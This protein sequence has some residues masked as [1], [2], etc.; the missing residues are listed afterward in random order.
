MNLWTLRGA[1]AASAPSVT[2]LLVLLAGCGEEARAPDP[3]PES[4]TAWV[5]DLDPGD[6][7]V[8]GGIDFERLVAE[9]EGERHENLLLFRGV[10]PCASCPGIRTLLTLVPENNVYV[11]RQTW[12]EAED[13][14]DR[15]ATTVGRWSE[16]VGLPDNPEALVFRL[17]GEPGEEAVA[18]FAIVTADL[19][20]MLDRE[21]RW[22]DS[23]L[24]YDLHRVN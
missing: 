3:A 16:E 7:T 10:L 9:L 22:I 8:Y 1:S 19:I 15:T 13:G 18:R 23:E 21:G 5:H 12:L 11:L 20:R 4:G 14:E 17:D 6:L 2:L 24:P